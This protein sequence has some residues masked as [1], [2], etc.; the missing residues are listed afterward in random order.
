MKIMP[1]YLSTESRTKIFFFLYYWHKNHL[2]KSFYLK[3][4][5]SDKWNKSIKNIY[6]ALSPI[7][8]LMSCLPGKVTYKKIYMNERILK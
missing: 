1:H 7:F 8:G 4:F 3:T 6:L 5:I 2:F